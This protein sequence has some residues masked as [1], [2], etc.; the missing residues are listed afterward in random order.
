MSVNQDYLFL[1]FDFYFYKIF[2]YY[3][4]KKTYD[5]TDTA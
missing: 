2:P 1:S 3:D 5:A 4:F